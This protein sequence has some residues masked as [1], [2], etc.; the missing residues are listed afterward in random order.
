MSVINY[1]LDKITENRHSQ[2]NILTFDNNYSRNLS[3]FY[4]NH[5]KACKGFEK[6]Q[7]EQFIESNEGETIFMATYLPYNTHV[8]INF[9]TTE[10]TT[11]TKLWYEV[12]SLFLLKEK[13]LPNI[14]IPI[15]CALEFKINLKYESRFLKYVNAPAYFISTSDLGKSLHELIDQEALTE[16]EI[17]E[18]CKQID[19]SID[20]Y[21]RI[22]LCHGN[23][24]PENVKIVNLNQKYSYK[25]DNM[26]IFTNYLAVIV[27]FRSMFIVKDS[28]LDIDSSNESGAKY[29][30]EGRY[31]YNTFYLSLYFL[32]LRNNSSKYTLLKKYIMDNVVSRLEYINSKHDFGLKSLNDVSLQ[33]PE[34]KQYK[35]HIKYDNIKIIDLMKKSSFPKTLISITNDALILGFTDQEIENHEKNVEEIR[36]ISLI[37]HGTIDRY[38]DY[39]KRYFGDINPLLKIINE[40]DSI[41]R[42]VESKDDVNIENKSAKLLKKSQDKYLVFTSI[43]LSRKEIFSDLGADTREYHSEILSMLDKMQVIFESFKL[44]HEKLGIPQNL[45]VF[46]DLISEVQQLW[47]NLISKKKKMSLEEAKED[48]EKASLKEVKKYYKKIRLEEAI[49]CYGEVKHLYTTF[50]DHAKVP[51][52]QLWAINIIGHGVNF[53]IVRYIT[54]Y[55]TSQLS[56]FLFPKE[57]K[58]ENVFFSAITETKIRAILSTLSKNKEYYQMLPTIE[59]KYNPNNELTRL[60]MNTNDE[61][62]NFYN[63]ENDITYND[64]FLSNYGQYNHRD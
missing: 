13:I 40:V 19:V 7:N 34:K 41:L 16:A 8:N 58:L 56:N 15:E 52:R 26:P 5:K 54:R 11:V 22:G 51:T 59:S 50:M 42:I 2:I 37:M 32:L 43:I 39:E 48:S 25:V 21:S 17:F 53:I 63:L 49:K 47:E 4:N 60:Y 9:Y 44:T 10:L 27:D 57:L 23:L 6:Y 46:S 38:T 3:R 14:E 64:I 24:I 30:F 62:I 36:K 31:D 33:L 18:I 29:D 55:I 20:V 45:S 61:I 1:V 12:I 35:N 28:I